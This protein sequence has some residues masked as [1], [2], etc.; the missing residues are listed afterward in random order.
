MTRADI[1]GIAVTI[2]GSADLSPETATA[3]L[4]LI[5]PLVPLKDR[6]PADRMPV[7]QSSD[8]AIHLVDLALPDWSISLKGR[9][10][11]ADGHWTCTLR[12]SD[13]LDDDFMIG[14]GRGPVLSH[15]ILAAMVRVAA[16]RSPATGAN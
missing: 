10:N 15:A 6:W 11:D 2:E 14:I 1:E 3:V 5:R 7:I 4:G 8:E 9:T 13:T 16:L 12:R